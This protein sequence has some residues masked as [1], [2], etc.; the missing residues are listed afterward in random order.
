MTDRES[1]GFFKALGEREK[2][3]N[4]ALKSLRAD[5]QKLTLSGQRNSEYIQALLRVA[6]ARDR[7][8]PR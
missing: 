5:V 6:E 3:L 7:R 8:R 4:Q 1:D 2:A